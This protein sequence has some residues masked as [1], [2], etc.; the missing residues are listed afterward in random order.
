MAAQEGREWG[1][2]GYTTQGRFYRDDHLCPDEP[3]SCNI[4]RVLGERFYSG[5]YSS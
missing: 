4:I 1:G 2:G 3:S 5:E